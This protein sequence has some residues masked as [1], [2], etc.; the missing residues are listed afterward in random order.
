MASTIGCPTHSR[1]GC[2]SSVRSGSLKFLPNL[3]LDFRFGSS[4]VP[5]LEPDHRFRFSAVRFRFRGGRTENQ[6]FFCHF[7]LSAV[8]RTS[9]ILFLTKLLRPCKVA[10]GTIMTEFMTNSR[11]TTTQS[12]L[13]FPL[14]WPAATVTPKTSDIIRFPPSVRHCVCGQPF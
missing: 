11:A 12:E 9:L 4:N 10:N 13:S 7:S 5:N 14:T 3:E 1:Q 2:R 6:T 8:K